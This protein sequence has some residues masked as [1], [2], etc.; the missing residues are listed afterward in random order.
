V[1]ATYVIGLREGLEAALIPDQFSAADPT[2]DVATAQRIRLLS[3]IV[4]E[5]RCR[6]PSTPRAPRWPA[7]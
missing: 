2:H 1:I 7:R 5:G 4:H 6:R 3:S